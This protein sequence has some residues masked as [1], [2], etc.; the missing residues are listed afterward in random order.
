VERPRHPDRHDR[1]AER[2]H[3]RGELADAVVVGAAAEADKEGGPEL[4]DVAAV[5]CP[6][7]G[8]P[9]DPVAEPGQR[10]LGSGR[11]GSPLRR[12]RS[13]DHGQV[14]DDHRGVLDERRVG[15]VVRGLDLDG[16]PSVV[17]ER[18]DVVLPLSGRELLVHREAIDVGGQA[19]TE[20]GARPADQ[21]RTS[22]VVGEKGGHD[23]AG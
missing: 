12:S 8:D 18:G 4:E 15:E 23:V 1:D 20:P 13:C 9:L 22:T 21:C 10:R 17:V 5:E 3:Q 2:R 11:L 16:R 14:A 19:V 7:V 6:G